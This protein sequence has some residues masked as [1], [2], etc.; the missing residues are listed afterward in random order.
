MFEI[1]ILPE[2]AKH[3]I[4]IDYATGNFSLK[5]I[6]YAQCEI[7]KIFSVQRE[8]DSFSKTWSFNLNLSG[9]P[10]IL[11]LSTDRKIF[12]TYEGENLISVKDELGRITKYAYEE[13]FLTQVIYPDGKKIKYTY[14]KYKNLK[15][16]TGRDGKIIFQ[17]DYDEIG[18]VTK[19]NN[20]NF[21]YDDQCWQVIEDEKIFYIRNRQK[22][23]KKII[24][25][26]NKEE[27]FEYDEKKNLIHKISRNG[28]E[29][30]WTYDNGLLMQEIFPNRLIKNFEYDENKNLIKIFDNLEREEIFKYSK[31]NLLVKK[32]TKLNIK[33]WR[34]ENFERDIIG[35]LVAHDVNGQITN[36]A[37]DD[38]SP[39]P[40]MEKTPCGY[41]FS[42]R[43]DDAYRLLAVR[44]EVGEFFL[45][46][47]QMNETVGDTKIFYEIEKP[48][49]NIPKS[50]IEI[51][52]FGRRL[53]ESRNRVGDKFK[54]SRWKY[55]LNDNCIERR[56]WK[57]LQD[58]E[59]ATGRVDVI[60]YFYD[61]QNRLIKKVEKNLTTIFKYDCLN[62]VVNVKKIAGGF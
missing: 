38:E 13:N 46:Y 59:S 8:Y 25:Q 44:T 6:D 29:N 41:N 52:D 34:V 33:D 15:S 22:L 24:Y 26:D 56:D 16:A 19:F 42:Y 54:L 53:I 18:R 45:A 58:I 49:K 51:F 40:T 20:R 9:K 32:S 10:K 28:E 55:D 35:R 37:Y 21:I 60:K 12:L 57:D 1:K 48:E 11:T 62:D 61:E 3:E 7:L 39:L 17:N 31:K 36:Y 27:N 50:D 4:K 30:F 2:L 43:Y 47:N 5:I 23:I 14:D